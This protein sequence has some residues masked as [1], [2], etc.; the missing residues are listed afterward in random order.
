VQTKHAIHFKEKTACAEEIT[1]ASA[2]RTIQYIKKC[3]C[4]CRR[5]TYCLCRHNT[6]YIFF[7]L[8]FAE[9]ITT[10]CAEITRIIIW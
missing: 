5:N 6:Q 4:M 3:S 7:K 8:A 9:K 10:A 2:N 1:I